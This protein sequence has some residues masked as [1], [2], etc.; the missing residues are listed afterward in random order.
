MAGQEAEAPLISRL[1]R[2]GIATLIGLM[3]VA[4]SVRQEPDRENPAP[5][6]FADLFSQMPASDYSGAKAR[7][8]VPRFSDQTK[9]DWFSREIAQ[10][11]AD[12]LMLELAWSGRYFLQKPRLGAELAGVG[13]G[14]PVEPEPRQDA[15]QRGLLVL[16]SITPQNTA[17]DTRHAP[18]TTHDTTRL[19]AMLELVD[20]ASGDVLATAQ[21][22]AAATAPDTN[23]RPLVGRL[24]AWRDTTLGAAFLRLVDRSADFLADHVPLDYYRYDRGGKL[25]SRAHIGGGFSDALEEAQSALT[26]L[27]HQ[28]GPIDG[29][30]GRQ[31]QQALQAFRD[32]QGSGQTGPLDIETLRAL[33]T[34]LERQK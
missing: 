9:A 32:R 28:P 7:I 29:L 25:S 6:S 1:V 3:A 26:A 16:V 30:P 34:Q 21:L 31:T 4:C 33:R 8:H 5:V 17:A 14:A 12:Q 24:S 22:N 27:G 10:S 11:M 19:A 2:F 20:V 18:A 15:A 23:A 13:G